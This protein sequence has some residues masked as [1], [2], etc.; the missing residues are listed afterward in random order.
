MQVKLSRKWSRLMLKTYLKSINIWAYRVY[1]HADHIFMITTC[2]IL[3]SDIRIAT[4]IIV[5]KCVNAFACRATCPSSN[6][7]L[8]VDPVKLYTC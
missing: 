6:V 8:H 4:A 5:Q 2:I 3:H 7:S 1:P